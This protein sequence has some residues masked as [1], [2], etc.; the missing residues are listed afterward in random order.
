MRGMKVKL[1]VRTQIFLLYAAR[2]LEHHLGSN[3][4]EV[5]E[6]LKKTWASEKRV[7]IDRRPLALSCPT[8]ST[9]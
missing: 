8:L 5:Q 7:M 9:R 2:W 4:R 3:P 1:Q 6:L